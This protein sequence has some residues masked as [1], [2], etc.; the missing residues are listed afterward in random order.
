[1]QKAE[2]E[3]H[4][5]LDALGPED[6]DELFA[7]AEQFLA[8]N[9]FRQAMGFLM[10]AVKAD[11]SR[12]DTKRA[13]VRYSNAWFLQ[14]YNPFME[15]VLV[16]C[17]KTDDLDCSS[18]RGI[19]YTLFLYH[20][21]FSRFFG[22]Q[23]RFEKHTL[24]SVKDLRPMLTPYFL[25]G[26][27]K[28]LICNRDFEKFLM[29][30]RKMLLQDVSSDTPAFSAQDR[31]ELAGAIACA[32]AFTEYIFETDAAEDEKYLSLKKKIEADKSPKA[33]E[34]AILAC[35]ESLHRL[36]SAAQ[37]AAS[38]KNDPH[39]S[40]VIRDQIELAEDLR[41]AESTIVALTAIDNAVSQ[42]V[43]GQYEEFPYPRWRHVLKPIETPEV[44]ESLPESGCK[45]L[46]A[47]CGTG[48][49]PVMFA[50]RFPEAKVLAVDLSHASLS[51][52]IYMAEK[53]G[54][55]NVEFRHGDILNLGIISDKFDMVTSSGV[56]H[57]MEDPVKGWRVIMDLLKPGGHMLIGLYSKIARRFVLQAQD[58]IKQKGYTL[59]AAGMRS[60]RSEAHNLLKKNVFDGI[61][62][63]TDFYNLSML[64]D[65]LFHVQEHDYDLPEIRKC[66]DEL[67]LKFVKFNMDDPEVF[68]RYRAMFPQDLPNG[69]LE[70]W[71]KFERQYPDTFRAMYQMWLKK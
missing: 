27:R 46:V 17:L 16:E 21:V 66:L 37:V 47:G 10:L 45:I 24:S 13:F 15:E 29:A 38:F 53:L 30:L 61:T 59:D 23:G 12:L 34:V 36:S 60:F 2:E 68:S 5:A 71:D 54:V 40:Q 63:A 28:L 44:F 26:L 64:R 52:G 51:Y 20:P 7:A 14:S 18:I 9:D 65:L 58:F 41:K 25:L 32:C 50:R 70:N 42:K 33:D 69:T 62:N 1:M 43:R 56:L 6:H 31:L 48:Q 8:A 35:Y 4:S 57:H 49:E 11:P 3:V 55:K 67:G 39:L 22:T 19:W